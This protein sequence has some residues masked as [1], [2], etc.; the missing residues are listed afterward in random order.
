MLTRSYNVDKETMK[1]AAIYTPAELLAF[2]A[3][4]LV[5]TSLASLSAWNDVSKSQRMDIWKAVESGNSIKLIK[6]IFTYILVKFWR[7]K[8]W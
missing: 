6:K 5:S 8:I 7:S 4:P 1:S 2:R 3:S